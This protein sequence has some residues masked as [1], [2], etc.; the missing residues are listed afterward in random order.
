MADNLVIVESPTKAGTIAKFLGKNYTVEASVGHIRD[1]PKSTL[2]IDIENGFEPKYMTI[3]GKADVVNTLKKKAKAA[4]KVYLATD[5]DREGEAISWHLAHLLNLDP[6]TTCRVTFNEITEKTVKSAIKNPQTINMDV[7]NAQQARRVLDRIVGYK[8]SPLLWKNVRKGLSAGR[9]QSVA[10]R[11]ICD[12]EEE[13][14]QF[15]PK[16]YWN[17]TVKL[18]K[19]NK[20]EAFL[21]KFYGT[22]A[23]KKMEILTE[24]QSNSILQSLENQQYTVKDVRNSKK[25]RSPMPPFTTSTLQQEASRKLGFQTRKTMQV[26]QQLYEGVDIKGKG[27]TGLVTYIR[28]DSVRLS[29]EAVS[30]IR[31][32]IQ[33]KYGTEYLPEKE[34]V[35]KNRSAAQNAHEAIRPSYP[36]LTPAEIKASLTND[37]YKLYKLI[38]DRFTSSQMTNA[39][40]DVLTVDITAGDYQFRATGSKVDFPGFMKVYMEGKDEKEDEKDEEENTNIPHLEAGEQLQ[41]QDLQSKQMF[42]QPPSRYT[43]ASLV[44][45]LEEKGIGRPSTYAPTI[46]T[47]VQ[48]GYIEREKK[49]LLPTELGK[50]VNEL[51]KNNFEDIVDIQFTATMESDLDDVEEGKENWKNVLARF[52]A[53]FSETI[54]TA[55]ENIGKVVIQ[56][57][58][59]D[60]A[61]EKCGRMMVVKNGTYGKFLAC[62][63]FPECRNTK[64]IVEE[65][66]VE[67]PK[68]GKP[69]IIRKTKKMKP[70]LACSGYPDC[71]YVNWD[72][73]V[74]DEKCEVCGAFKV[75]HYF[76][77]GKSIHKCGDPECVTNAA[78]GGEE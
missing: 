22:A 55:E 65:A 44:K 66:G 72:M 2:G 29:E 12:R 67:C 62:P 3:R 33:E 58:V 26:A 52:Y 49:T 4:K 57:E 25:S 56:E 10:T 16:E 74:K 46:S 42:T 76:K 8:I 18:S 38:W 31:D 28:T 78:A 77:G 13:I 5:P 60:V 9:V 43:E 61:C 15:V 68:C 19:L 23:G 14:E 35:Y 6:S 36:I 69:V 7:V 39:Q 41:K 75:K 59:S 63:G 21:A 64:N 48:R 47:I 24:E 1:L 73:P 27:T 34:R 37:Q 45:T 40:I 20:K 53:E 32:L 11:I 51:M 17:M 71:K 50:I 70:Y 30:E 54:K